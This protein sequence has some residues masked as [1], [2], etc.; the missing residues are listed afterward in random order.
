MDPAPPTVTTASDDRLYRREGGPRGVSAHLERVRISG[1]DP[2]QHGAT[3]G[4][5]ALLGITTLTRQ[6]SQFD[7]YA[8]EEVTAVVIDREHIEDL[9]MTKP[10][11]LQELGRII[12]QRPHPV[13]S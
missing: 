6:A 13:T 3:L 4:Q 8:L 10:L 11:L 12:D 7:A 5:G 9:V 1:A 2:A